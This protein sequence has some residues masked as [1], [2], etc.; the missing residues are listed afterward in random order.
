MQFILSFPVGPQGYP[1][2]GLALLLQFV[3][4]FLLIL[5]FELLIM[6]NLISLNTCPHLCYRGK[7]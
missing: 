1:C 6:S 2:V 4:D 7:S 5:P 3:E